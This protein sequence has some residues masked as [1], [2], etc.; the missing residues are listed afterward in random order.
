MAAILIRWL[1]FL[2]I[3]SALMFYMA[4]GTSAAMA[5]KIRKETDFA[6]IRAMLDLS[7]STM[8]IMGVS[9]LIMGLTGLILPFPI[10]I[11]N[12]G[13]IWVSIVLMVFVFV[14][15]AMFNETSYKQLRRLVGLPY[16]KGN[17]ELPAEPPSSPEEVAAVLNKTNITGLIIAGYV[18]PAI[19]LWLM[20]FK[21]F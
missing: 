9:F 11:W 15:M 5:F 1:I 21:P 13:Y 3:L 4:H 18:V 20:V 19:V 6:R 7:S 14:Y 2:H 12:K 16:M 8:I 17:K 10:H